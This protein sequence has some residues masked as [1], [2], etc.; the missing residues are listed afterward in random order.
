MFVY[1]YC[2]HYCDQCEY[3]ANIPAHLKLH[4]E[5]KHEGIRYPC[6]HCEFSS[7][8]TYYL[9]VHIKSRHSELTSQESAQNPVIKKCFPCEQCDFV[10]SNSSN[11]KYHKDSKHRGIKYTCD[12][13]KYTTAHQRSLKLHI[14]SR[15][16][17][18]RYP[19]DHC[20]YSA[21][22]RTSVKKH[23]KSKHKGINYPCNYC[24]YVATQISNLRTHLKKKHSKYLNDPNMNSESFETLHVNVEGFVVKEE[25]TEA[26]SFSNT[27]KDILSTTEQDPLDYPEKTLDDTFHVVKSESIEEEDHLYIK[28]ELDDYDLETKLEVSNEKFI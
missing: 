6:D 22:D 18:I 3:S 28:E 23:I 27:N 24:G 14:E 26:D 12:Q 19:C 20:D 21:S 5:Y 11:L 25:I 4:K 2:R 1:P 17:G 16:E 9:K 10:A 13:C 8:T 7:T 15:H